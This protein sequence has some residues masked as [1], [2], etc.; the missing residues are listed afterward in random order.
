MLDEL[1]AALEE[2]SESF[3][4]EDLDISGWDLVYYDMEPGGRW[5][6]FHTYVYHYPD[7]GRWVETLVAQGA[8]E[9]QD[10]VILRSFQEVFPKQIVKTVYVCKGDL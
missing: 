7:E 8:T 2:G 4:I 9:Y 6:N 5:D 1:A 3:Y 10:H